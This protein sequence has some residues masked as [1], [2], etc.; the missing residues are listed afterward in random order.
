MPA[1]IGPYAAHARRAYDIYAV[2]DQ[3][4]SPNAVQKF[5][6]HLLQV[7]VWHTAAERQ[8]SVVAVP[9]DIA[10]SRGKVIANAAPPLE[11]PRCDAWHSDAHIRVATNIKHS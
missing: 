4:N 10:D 8:V 11:R 6:E 9:R 5:L 2:G 1:I 3:L 7:K